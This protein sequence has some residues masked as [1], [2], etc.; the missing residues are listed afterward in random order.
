MLITIPVLNL[1]V[2]ILLRLLD[3]VQGFHLTQHCLNSCLVFYSVTATCFGRM[4]IFKWLLN[5]ILNNCSN[6]VALDGYPEP[7]LYQ[8]PRVTL[9]SNAFT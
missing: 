5:K 7:E 9:N 4:T 8:W 6:S 1:V 2:C 3:Q